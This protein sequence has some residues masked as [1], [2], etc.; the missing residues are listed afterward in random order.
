MKIILKI[1]VLI[2]ILSL[3]VICQD[4]YFWKE[5]PTSGTKIYSLQFFD[6]NNGIAESQSGEFLKTTDRGDHWFLSEEKREVQLNDVWSAEIYCSVMKTDDGG[7]TWKP[8]LKEPQEH[9]CLVYFKDKNTG[10]M[11]AEEFLIKV[12]NTINTHI[13][14]G[15]IESLMNQPLQCT[16][17]YTNVDAGWALGWCIRG[18]ENY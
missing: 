10:W 15:D 3:I 12:V 1:T 9:F 13:Q 17:Y 16:E 6:L 11:V 14:N 7:L 2:N 5:A 4:K 18:F 8:Y